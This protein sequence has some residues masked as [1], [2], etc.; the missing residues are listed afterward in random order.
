MFEADLASRELRKGDRKIR[1]QDQPFQIL[2]VFLERPGEVVTKE[3]LIENLWGDSPPSAP[4]HSLSIAIGK[5]RTALGDSADNPRF[6]ETLPASAY[7]FIATVEFV[8]EKPRAIPSFAFPLLGV[9]VAVA[10]AVMLLIPQRDC[11]SKKVLEPVV[12]FEVPCEKDCASPVISPDGSHVAFVSG[13]GTLWVHDFKEDERRALPGTEE[14]N[15]PFW[16]PDS[17]WIGFAAA[18][19]LKKVRFDGGPA[20]VLCR[21]LDRSFWG[22]TWSPDLRSI[23]FGVH[24]PGSLPR[25]YEVSAQGGGRPELLFEPNDEERKM[26][27]GH[28]HFLP[29]G[30]GPRMLLYAAGFPSRSSIVLRNLDTGEQDVLG[31]GAAPA[32]SPSGY[33]VY[34]TSGVVGGLWALPFS[35]DTRK[36]TGASSAVRTNGLNPSV[37]DGWLVYLNRGGSVRLVWRDRSGKKLGAIGEPQAG[38]FYPALSP[39]ER[40]VAV[41]GI[42]GDT[43]NI[44]IH[45]VGRRSKTR[46]SVERGYV[47]V[48][49]WSPDGKVTYSASVDGIINIYRKPARFDG[50]P[51]VLLAGT[52]HDLPCDWSE[53]GRH[54]LFYR[55][56]PETLRDIWYLRRRDDGSG[57]EERL[58]LQT[59]FWEHAASFSP[60][61]RFVVYVSDEAG[62]YDVYVRRFPEGTERWKVSM[63]KSG[64]QPR[65]S[66]DG[67]EIFYVEGDTL[68]AASVSTEPTFAVKGRRRLFTSALLR[69]NFVPSYDVS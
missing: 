46:L 53:D 52:F 25:L 36:P 1:L 43:E 5:I 40:A 3:E 54:L 66:H 57:Y 62:R 47:S 38:I 34:Q 33:I 19:E 7:R 27:F 39:D 49:I 50:D 15:S 18:D 61:G 41:R 45:E 2:A 51:E 48:P 37:A 21:L 55:N 32:Y 16:S 29:L 14:A 20:V 6:I 35:L 42:E 64:A 31:Y 9:G 17:L 26:G 68:F 11:G 65:W 4:D 13:D 8:R 23:V 59:P 30:E 56:D 24:N 12:R 58:F 69:G 63:D 28:P 60:D 67:K 44:W 10:A 22:G